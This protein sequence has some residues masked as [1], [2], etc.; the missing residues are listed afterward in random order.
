M[1]RHYIE[2][3][4][5]GPSGRPGARRGVADADESIIRCPVMTHRPPLLSSSP[6]SN[7]AAN[8]HVRLRKSYFLLRCSTAWLSSRTLHWNVFMYIAYAMRRPLHNIWR[9]IEFLWPWYDVIE[10]PDQ[11]FYS[12]NCLK[13]VSARPRAQGIGEC[14]CRG[15][16]NCM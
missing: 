16:I 3:Q 12:K 11:T 5:S 7:K 9:S 2:K 6:I 10:A 14:C 13:L 4:S 15:A 1:V 8:S